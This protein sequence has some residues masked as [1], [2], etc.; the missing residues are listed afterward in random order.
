[1]K[2]GLLGLQQEPGRE[3][4]ADVFF[5]M[6]QRKQLGLIFQI[7]ARRVAKRVARAAILLV[8]Q[9]ANVRRVLGFMRF[10]RHLNWIDIPR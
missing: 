10:S 1:M 9:I 3:P 5:G 6:E 2:N 8:E 7:R 4:H